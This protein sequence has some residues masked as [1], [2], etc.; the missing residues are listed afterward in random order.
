[1]YHPQQQLIYIG[2]KYENV[3]QALKFSYGKYMDVSEG[4]SRLNVVRTVNNIG[5]KIIGVS[6]LDEMVTT[7]KEIFTFMIW[8]L[9]IV[10]LFILLIS[11]FMSARIS[12][13]I[14]RLKK[15]MEMVE[16]GHF[17]T[18]IHVRGADEVEQ[19][20]RRFNLM[21]SRVR[22]LMDQS[23]EEQE[24][25]RKNELE[26]LQSQINPHFLYRYT[27]FGGTYGWQREERRG[28]DDDYVPVEVFPDIAQQR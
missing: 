21:V 28:C 19:L 6:Y 10:L 3:E 25:K 24:I 2:L 22:E 18:Y 1:M 9:V 23:I 4:E 14:K 15:S 20:S 16:K 13:P 8:L 27:Q 7:R 17:D 26:V 11:S 5:W 12:Q